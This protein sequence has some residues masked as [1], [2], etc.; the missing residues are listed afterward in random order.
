MKKL[1]IIISIFTIQFSILNS[2]DTW[3]KTYDPFFGD[4]Y[5]TEDVLICQDGGYAIN[6]YY[7]YSD[8]TWEEHW[9]FLVKTDSDGNL[10]WAKVDTVSFMSENES[11]A[12]IET[13]DEGF[14][15]A[16]SSPWGSYLIKR[17]SLGNRLW[18]MFNDFHVETM[19]RAVDG[20]IILG[21]IRTDNGHPAI[22]KITQEGNVLWN[23]DYYLGGSGN[24]KIRS[25]I[26]TSDGG[27]ASTGLTSGGGFNMFV[28][29]TDSNGDSLWCITYDGFGQYDE[30][31]SII[32]STSA[33]F[34]V[35][36]LLDDLDRSIYGIL[37]KI[38]AEGELLLELNESQSGNYYTF[39]SMV[40][41]ITD[42]TIVGYGR[43]ADGRALN[44]YNYNG[45]SILDTP[46]PLA[47][48]GIGDK[49]LQIV[50][51]GFL[52]SGNN[53]SWHIALVKT[54]N[55]GQ[56]T[57]SDNH[58]LQINNYELNNYPN[59]F[60]PET[61]IKFK[62]TYPTEVLLQ[63]F[64]VKGQL[65]TTLLNEEKQAGENSVIWNA[66]DQA[67]G[68]YFIRISDENGLSKNHKIVLI[69]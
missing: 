59:P 35:S 34:Y 56:V 61:T 46:L 53:S 45:E 67:S 48:R 65:I 11:L 41:S 58:E 10:L 12:F 9:G 30:G 68:I 63:I 26:Q 19:L 69:K 29:K 51:N 40:E 38:S 13:D 1:L 55:S 7:D 36:G 32:E 6:G 49:C 37:L 27:F 50:D 22:R 28:L 3:I 15:S 52:L 16:G 60:N 18:S 57:S 8:F 14:L 66:K 39:F 54:D 33:E 4:T 2:E 24:G 42:N 23:Q 64:N 43:D 25:V 31:L 44:F 17:D 20:N 47:G 62:I 21:G 5:A